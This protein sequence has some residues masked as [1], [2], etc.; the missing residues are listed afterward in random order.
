MAQ[1][2]DAPLDR[3]SALPDHLCVLA[4]ELPRASWPSHPRFRGLAAFWLERHLEF[5][6]L[7]AGLER[8]AESAIDGVLAPDVWQARLSRHGS[9]LVSHLGGHHEIEDVHYFPLL[10]RMEPRLETGFAILEGD[11]RDLAERLVRF[12]DAANAAIAAP[13]PAGLKDATGRLRDGL[14]QFGRVL[15]RHLE[16]EED[17]VVPV[18]LKHRVG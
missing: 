9:A 7:V 14:A 1:D 11:H 15:L 2:D 17:L 12:V 5:R 3:R 10:E 13:D 18:I 4:A 16:D 8:D 6:R